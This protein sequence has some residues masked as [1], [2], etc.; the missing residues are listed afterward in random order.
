[1]RA[2][3][4]NVLAT[5]LQ[6]NPQVQAYALETDTLELLTAL[7]SDEDKN[8]RKKAM[9]AISALVREFAP[10]HKVFLHKGGLEILKGTLADEEQS[11]R[12]KSLF[13]LRHLCFSVPSCRDQLRENGTLETILALVTE[14]DRTVREQALSSLLYLMEDNAANQAVCADP[15]NNLRANLDAIVN[16]AASAPAEEREEMEE[17]LGYV[18]TLRAVCFA[19]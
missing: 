13:L 7:L 9:Y 3:S 19:A 11:V 8:V 5:A 18:A 16:V 10:S 2:G 12:I 17:E 1:V 15:K 4:A 14:D 6:N